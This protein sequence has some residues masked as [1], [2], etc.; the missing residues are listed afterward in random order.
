[1]SM[2]RS[3]TQVAL[4]SMRGGKHG[5]QRKIPKGS[6]SSITSTV[7][8]RLNVFAQWHAT[9]ATRYGSTPS[10]MLW[11]CP[12]ILSGSIP[13]RERNYCKN[14]RV[15]RAGRGDSYVTS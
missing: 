1:M 8:E 15:R 12:M 14:W 3:G 4:A 5:E 10:D 9:T 6:A 2:Q 13:K 11:F 7:L